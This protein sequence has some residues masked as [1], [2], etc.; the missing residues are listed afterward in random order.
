MFFCQLSLKGRQ[1]G[2]H[3]TVLSGRRQHADVTKPCIRGYPDC[4]KNDHGEHFNGFTLQTFAYKDYSNLFC[5][6]WVGRS[7]K[8]WVKEHGLRE[9][10]DPTTGKTIYRKPFEGMIVLSA[11]LE[12]QISLSLREARDR[13]KLP[14]SK[15]APMLGLSEQ[16]YGRYENKVSRLT[17]GR[18]IHLCEVLGATPE[19]IIA[20]AAPHLWGETKGR[21]ELILACIEKLRCFDE[22]TLRDVFSLLARL[23]EGDERPTDDALK[24]MTHESRSPH[25]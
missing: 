22:E 18:L 21:A 9:V 1:V 6:E 19:E 3:L 12:R 15:L 11:E 20:P 24:V 14:R 4:A 2:I 10:D 25:V 8:H 23:S 13:R 16:V 7:L 17:V 5:S